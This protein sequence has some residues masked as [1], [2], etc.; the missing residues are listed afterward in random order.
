MRHIVYLK[1]FYKTKEQKKLLL[2]YNSWT[3]TIKNLKK[4]YN[5]ASRQI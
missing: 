1:G 5:V 2:S 3:K 4:G